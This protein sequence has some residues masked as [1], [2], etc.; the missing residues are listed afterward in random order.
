MPRPLLLLFLFVIASH[1]SAQDGK[2]LERTSY[3]VAG[4]AIDARPMTMGAQ[5]SYSRIERGETDP[6][7]SRV[8]RSL[9]AA[10]YQSEKPPRP[11]AARYRFTHRCASKPSGVRIHSV[12][13]PAGSVVMSRSMGVACTTASC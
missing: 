6:T 8:K 7:W 5:S 9:R 4:C 11:G 1:I 10:D 12:Y 13:M 3:T 2:L